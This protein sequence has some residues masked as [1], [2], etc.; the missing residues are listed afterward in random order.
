MKKRDFNRD[1]LEEEVLKTVD[2]YEFAD[3]GRRA[4]WRGLLRV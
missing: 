3:Y 1:K 4:V 2:I